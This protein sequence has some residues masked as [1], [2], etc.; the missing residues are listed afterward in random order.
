MFHVEH[1]AEPPASLPYAEFREYLVKDNLVHSLSQHLAY[2][3]Q[4]LSKRCAAALRESSLVYRRR[5]FLYPFP[6]PDQEI[7]MPL[8]QYPGVLGGNPREQ[9]FL[10]GGPQLV[11]PCAVQC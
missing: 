5:R 9:P 11:Q 4:A 6:C 10:G 8:P 1:V 3:R 2:C 7:A